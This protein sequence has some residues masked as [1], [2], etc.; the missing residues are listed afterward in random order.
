MKADNGRAMKKLS[1]LSAGL[2]TS[3]LMSVGCLRAAERSGASLFAKTQTAN[4]ELAPDPC[5]CPC[6]WL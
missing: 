6:A 4:A 2:V 1:H 5:I 3:L